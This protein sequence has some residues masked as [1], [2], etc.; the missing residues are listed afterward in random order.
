MEKQ[1]PDLDEG[2]KERDLLRQNRYELDTR[3]VI[4]DGKR[5]PVAVIC[6][7]GAYRV[8]ASFIEGVPIAKK[9]NEK[10][11]SAL[12]VYYRIGEKALCPAPMDDLAKAVKETLARADAY[13]IDAETYSLWGA[14]AGGHLAASFGTKALGYRHYGLP[15]PAA[16]VLSYPVITMDRAFTHAETRTNLLGQTSVNAGLEHLLSIDEQVTGSFPPTY[17]WC[18]DADESV[19]PENTR[20]MAAALEKAG[21]PYTCEVFPDVGH[22]VGPGTGTAAEGWIERAVAFWQ[23]QAG[24]TA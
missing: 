22:G 15:K 13:G 14:S 5:H 21:V 1:L 23:A 4:R 20:R 10:G 24:F 16:I 6:P 9:L 18:G 11:I 17:L 19:P 8:V 12:I 2:Q 3:F 7:G